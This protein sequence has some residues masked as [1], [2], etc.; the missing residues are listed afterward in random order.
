MHTQDGEGTLPL[1]LRASVSTA[2]QSYV[3]SSAQARTCGCMASLISLISLFL[4][5]YWLC[6]SNQLFFCSCLP[7]PPPCPCLPWS[8]MPTCSVLLSCLMSCPTT[9]YPALPT[10]PTLSSYLI[11]LCERRNPCMSMPA[12]D[13][14]VLRV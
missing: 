13:Q 1:L 10:L 9:P 12:C 7:S 3:R 4:F 2:E 11:F 5:L 8:A 14:R 6:S